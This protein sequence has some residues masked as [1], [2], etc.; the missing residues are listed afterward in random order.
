ML[1]L[2]YCQANI[3]GTEMS[4]FCANSISIDK[5]NRT[6]KVKGGDNNV[7]PR[8]NYWSDYFPIAG[9]IKEL[10]GGMIQFTTRKDRHI[11]I[12]TL[13]YEYDKKMHDL[14]GLSSYEVADLPR[15]P[16]KTLHEY[17]QFP[18]DHWHRKTV[19]K[20]I[21]I[22][23]DRELLAKIVEIKKE[24]VDKVIK[25]KLDK[26][27][28]IIHRLDDDVYVTGASKSA[29]YLTRDIIFAKQFTKVKAKDVIRGYENSNYEIVLVKKEDENNGGS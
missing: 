4:Y 24:F 5:K 26:T 28:H 3:R 13:A 14:T 18:A 10:S 21:P 25:I 6:C 23:E 7:V 27:K 20:I 12:E 17:K 29:L 15:E 1:A 19:D 11:V 2:F 22:L 8:S 16:Q 9:L